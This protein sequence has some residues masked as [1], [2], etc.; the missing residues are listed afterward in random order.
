M[1]IKGLTVRGYR[2]L[3]NINVENLTNFNVFVGANDSGKSNVLKAIDLFFNWQDSE[4]LGG[5]LETG[6]SGSSLSFAGR[7]ENVA[8]FHGQKPGKVELTVH[9]TIDEKIESLLP[10]K[11]VMHH[12][13]G[14][15]FAA[16][17]VTSASPRELTANTP[18]TKE[19]F[20]KNLGEEIIVSEEIKSD[21]KT[22]EGNVSWITW[23]GLYILRPTKEEFRWLDSQDGRQYTYRQSASGPQ[24]PVSKLIEALRNTYVV[25]PAVRELIAEKETNASALSDGKNVPSQYLRYEKDVSVNKQDTYRR[26]RGYVSDLFPEYENTASMTN[27]KTQQVDVHFQGFPSASVGDGVKNAFLISFNV[28]SHLGSICG[29]EEPEIHF[30]PEKQRELHR[31]LVERSLEKQIF[32]T[33]HSPTFASMTRLTDLRLVT[34]DPDRKTTD[35]KPIDSETVSDVI[36]ELGVRPGDI[37]D[38]D[39]L[40]FVEGEDDVKILKALAKKLVANSEISVGFVDSEGWNSMAYYANARILKSRKVK[41]IVFTV[42]DGDTEGDEK[43]RKIKERLIADLKISPDHIVTFKK[44]SIEAYLLVPSAIKRALPQIRLS[45][46]EIKAFISANE[47]K[48]NKKDVLDKLLKRGGIGS[49]SGQLGAE[50][51]DNMPEDEIDIELRTIMNKFSQSVMTS[52]EEKT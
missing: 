18:D 39:I 42:F 5:L 26:V 20:R 24:S 35:V 33:T 52:P 43:Y 11:F 1:L 44:S 37:F 25:V 21:G 32:V 2:S 9:L 8:F 36:T 14:R 47:S 19:I 46:E 31:F 4:E 41:V 16:P 22:M 27:E 40:V 7:T 23:G 50:I 38:Y 13:R 29:I 48:K 12:Q 10:E 49:Y 15:E 30:H 6:S 34:I 45:E 51:A 3:K 28:G 17:T